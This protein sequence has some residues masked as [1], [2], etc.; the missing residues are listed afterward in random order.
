MGTRHLIMVVHGGETK[1]AQ[2]GQWD[3]YPSGQ[4]ITV[5]NFLKKRSILKFK[6]KLSNC[7]FMNDDD[8]KK[9]DNFLKSIGS[10]DGW[11]N[12]EQSTKYHEAYPYL[13]RDIGADILDI[14]YKSQN[15]ILLQDSSE[16][17]GNS[18][19]CEWG[20]IIDL[21]QNQLEVYEGF[22]EEIL[23]KGRFSNQPVS[24]NGYGQIKLLKTYYLDDLPTPSQFVADLT[25]EEEVGDLENPNKAIF[26]REITVVDP[27]TNAEVQLSVYKHN[28]GGMLAIDS[29]FIEQ[30][31]SDD[32]EIYDPFSLPEDPEILYLEEK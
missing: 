17:A 23:T 10:S 5:L 21:D 18:L 30:V 22:N 26:V 19:F 16:F 8:K 3:G 15:E 24:D 4:G 12:D 28:N 25:P 6:K 2:Y 9:L 1:V 27:D 7:R 32:G 11:L 31:L 29:S 20:Y 13:S 14:I